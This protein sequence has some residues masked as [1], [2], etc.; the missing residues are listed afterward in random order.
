M[1]RYPDSLSPDDFTRKA[2]TEAR[3]T[4]SWAVELV[5]KRFKEGLDRVFDSAFV[6]R[7]FAEFARR[8]TQSMSPF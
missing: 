4:H 3:G 8:Q 1:A 6:D 2:E 5:T 7:R